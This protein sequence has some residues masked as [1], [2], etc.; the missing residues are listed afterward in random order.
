MKPLCTNSL[1]D[2]QPATQ[3][4]K[5]IERNER[6]LREIT[7]GDTDLHSLGEEIAASIDRNPGILR[8]FF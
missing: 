6:H 2:V 3:K 8:R 5:Q 4:T 1:S 7:A